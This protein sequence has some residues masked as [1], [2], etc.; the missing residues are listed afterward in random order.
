MRECCTIWE[1][2]I[3]IS[4][5]IKIGVEES[6]ERSWSLGRI[7][8]KKFSNKF[9]CIFGSSVSENLFPR[10]R[11]YLWESVFSVIGVHCKDL[12]ARRSSQ[13]FNDFDE[14]INATFTRENRLTKHKFCDDATDGPYINVCAIV[15]VTEYQFRSAIVPRADV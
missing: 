14:L 10:K 1:A 4:E 2:C 13:N 8:T 6:D 12:F 15:R 3:W 9:D 7:I 5:F 11:F